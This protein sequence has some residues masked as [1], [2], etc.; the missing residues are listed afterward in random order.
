MPVTLKIPVAAAVVIFSASLTA[1]A[2]EPPRKPPVPP[3]PHEFQPRVGDKLTAPGLGQEL[4][5]P[6]RPAGQNKPEKK[7]KPK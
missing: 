5:L 4:V 7:E 1:S 6:S 2:Q 3:E